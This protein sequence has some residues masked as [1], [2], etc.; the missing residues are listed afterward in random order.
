MKFA[1]SAR[2]LAGAATVF[3]AL[4][5]LGFAVETA[6]VQARFVPERLDDFAWEN[7]L[8]AFRTYGPALRTG[9]ED[10]GIDCWMKR[11]KTPVIDK[12]YA[13][14]DY[15]ADHGE[16]LDFY[17]VG[18]SR[19]CGGI[20]LVTPDGKFKI[21]DTFVAWRVIE[22]KPSS[23]IFELDYAYAGTGITETKRIAIRAGER[24]CRIESHFFRNGK[25]AALDV[26][27]GITTHEG[28]GE[29]RFDEKAGWMRVWEKFGDNGELGTGVVVRDAR[30]KIVKTR[31][32]DEAHIWALTK[33]DANGVVA[34]DA[35]YGWTKAGEIKDVQAWEHYLADFA[36]K[37]HG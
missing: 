18:S 25:P 7:D 23:A 20:A 12:W 27:I 1:V 26:A 17:N 31:A 36:R 33:T 37:S 34:W 24:L 3:L 4:G 15:H 28:A 11:V 2:T 14:G 8:V 6:V 16:G 19:G 22:K 10:S 5:S 9:A 13:S 32:K 30:F 35:G 21:S 29:P